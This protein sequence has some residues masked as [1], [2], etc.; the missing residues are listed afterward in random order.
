MACIDD[1]ISV[2]SSRFSLLPVLEKSSSSSFSS[3]STQTA[4]SQISNVKIKTTSGVVALT[5][6]LLHVSVSRSSLDDNSSFELSMLITESRVPTTCTKLSYSATLTFTV[7]L[8]LE[9]PGHTLITGS[10]ETGAWL[11][12]SLTAIGQ[13]QGSDSYMAKFE[14]TDVIFSAN[15][16]SKFS[17]MQVSQDPL[18]AKVRVFR[19]IILKDLAV[20]NRGVAGATSDNK[21]FVVDIEN[22]EEESDSGSS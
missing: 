2:N 8:D 15:P 22:D 5:N 20:S 7:P 6:A 16:D 12:F 3:S 13:M 21:L 17:S 10:T 4:M 9:L 11:H 19:G 18:S 14:C 1:T